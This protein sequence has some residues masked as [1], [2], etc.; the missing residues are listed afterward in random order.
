[1]HVHIFT[2]TYQKNIHTF[3][4]LI[5]A[6]RAPYPSA[7]ATSAWKESGR[8]TYIV[9]ACAYIRMCLYEYVS[10]SLAETN[11]APFAPLQGVC[12]KEKQSKGMCVHTYVFI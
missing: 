12:T 10:T 6:A 3:L 4:T 1:M 7:S 5:S 2:L 8:A 11:R 9:R